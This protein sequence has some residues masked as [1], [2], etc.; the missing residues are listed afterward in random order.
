MRH[1]SPRYL[2]QQ[3]GAGLGNVEAFSCLGRKLRA[4]QTA[5]AQR[6]R[7]SS[8]FASHSSPGCSLMT[9]TRISR[10]FE[11]MPGGD[12]CKILS[13]RWRHVGLTAHCS[14]YRFSSC[15]TSRLKARLLLRFGTGPKLSLLPPASNQHACPNFCRRKKKNKKNK[16]TLTFTYDV[17]VTVKRDKQ[18]I[19]RHQ[20]LTQ[21]QPTNEAEHWFC[22]PPPLKKK[23]KRVQSPSAAWWNRSHMSLILIKQPDLNLWNLAV[24]RD[25]KKPRI[26]PSLIHSS[27]EI[28]WSA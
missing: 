5:H 9:N 2:Q 18:A 13:K 28:I 4:E 22:T 14:S 8:C 6:L 26:S 20:T 23:K 27:A 19:W 1:Y 24:G 10:G 3:L 25:S 15:T 21:V 12:L 11:I 16:K 17:S 7:F